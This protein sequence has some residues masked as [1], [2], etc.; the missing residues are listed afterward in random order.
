MVRLLLARGATADAAMAKGTPMRRTSQN[1]DLPAALIPSTPYLLAARFLEP[2]V[3]PLLKGAGAD[4]QAA[5]LETGAAA[6][7][8]DLL[9][10]LGAID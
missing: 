6:N 7:T 3:V 8:A 10:S 4:P 9:Q 5:L 2:E 1:Y